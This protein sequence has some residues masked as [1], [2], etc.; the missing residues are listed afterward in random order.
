MQNASVL[1]DSSQ[2]SFISSFTLNKCEVID[3]S[4]IEVEVHKVEVHRD[5]KSTCEVWHDILTVKD[6]AI[7]LLEPYMDFKK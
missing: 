3:E 4:H 5:H 6:A 7:V 2:V 1:D